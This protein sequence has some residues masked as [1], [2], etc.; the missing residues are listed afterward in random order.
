MGKYLDEP[1]RGKPPR[2]DDDLMDG[3][4]TYVLQGRVSRACLDA[5]ESY[6]K[7]K[8]GRKGDRLEELVMRALTL[9]LDGQVPP[10]QDNLLPRVVPPDLIPVESALPF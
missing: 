1:R 4:S 3:R 7:E 2:H 9:P 8:G 5:F 6:V 10:S